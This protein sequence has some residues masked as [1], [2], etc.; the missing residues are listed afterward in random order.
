MNNETSDLEVIVYTNSE[1]LLE[2][3]NRNKISI[4][5]LSDSF[6]IP[7]FYE[8][9][10][11]SV[12]YFSE[13]N[14]RSE[15]LKDRAIFKYQSIDSIL[16]EVHNLEM[17]QNYENDTVC[18]QFKNKSM[19]G[20][21]SPNY[22][23]VQMIFSLTCAS[24]L[25]RQSKVLYINLMENAGISTLFEETYEEDIGDYFYYLKAKK[26][27]SKAKLESLI[28]H[29]ETY[30]YIPPVFHGKNLYELDEEDYK[31]FI[32]QLRELAYDNILVDCGSCNVG[33]YEIL[34]FS[35]KIYCLTRE[36]IFAQ[37]R[38]KHFFE[39]LQNEEFHEIREKISVCPL[40]YRISHQNIGRNTL[41]QLEWGELADFIRSDVL[42]LKAE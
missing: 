41:S 9:N 32:F 12:I 20:I 25:G 38:L 42:F 13:G 30:D 7:E 5:L 27:S 29:Q 2:Y 4:F 31:K 18:M 15:D 16:R 40:S 22:D 23:E 24:I 10:Q 14:L 6:W 17:K 8:S 37:S 26:Q 35:E 1:N 21:F 19:I 39:T 28:Y 34:R 3:T 11:Q 33:F 36:N